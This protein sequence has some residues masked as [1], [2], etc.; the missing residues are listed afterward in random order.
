MHFCSYSIGHHNLIV[1]IVFGVHNFI[2]IFLPDELAVCPSALSGHRLDTLSV[3]CSARHCVMLFMALMV[4]H[5]L[6]AEQIWPTHNKIINLCDAYSAGL[7]CSSSVNVKL[8]RKLNLTLGRV[9]VH[10]PFKQIDTAVSTAPIGR[11][12]S[13]C[14][15]YPT[16]LSVCLCIK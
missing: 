1:F 3:A 15:V 14:I 13:Q 11:H 4:F 12:I 9:R 7:K 6:P 5:H 10:T 16:A 8:R 2:I